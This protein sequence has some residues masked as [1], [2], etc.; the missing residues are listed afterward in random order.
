VWDGGEATRRC[1][2]CKVHVEGEVKF[3]RGWQR[4]GPDP[5]PPNCWKDVEG[6]AERL[7]VEGEVVEADRPLPVVGNK[8]L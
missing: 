3:R 6:R 4:A 8:T 1:E 2:S 7:K 5:G